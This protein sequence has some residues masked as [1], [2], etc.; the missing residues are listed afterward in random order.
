MEKEPSGQVQQSSRAPSRQKWPSSKPRSRSMIGF[1]KTAPGDPILVAQR[2]KL[3]Q[4]LVAK[5][6]EFQGTKSPGEAQLKASRDVTA[7][8]KVVAK[9]E[10]AVVAAN[11][12]SEAAAA[13]LQQ[14]VNKFAVD[15]QKLASLEATQIAAT[16]RL[17]DEQA[18]AQNPASLCGSVQGMLV[19]ASSRGTAA[20]VLS[21]QDRT[22]MDQISTQLAFIT[23]ALAG[24]QG[25][26]EVAEQ[27]QRQQQQLQPQ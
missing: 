16:K 24:I 27:H 15:K 17:H 20:G 2:D 19:N 6:A 4:Q 1:L 23:Q 9:S 14:A 22:D 10:A 8:Q 18:V 13:K 25:R 5:R 21:A 26:T 12:A 11:S 3:Q 7:A